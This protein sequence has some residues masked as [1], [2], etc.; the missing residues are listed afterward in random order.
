MSRFRCPAKTMPGRSFADSVTR[1]PIRPVEQMAL[2][3]T[4]ESSTITP[5]SDPIFRTP[6]GARP[7]LDAFKPARGRCYPVLAEV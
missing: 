5:H 4:S 2:G 3:N 1:C 6:A 7:K